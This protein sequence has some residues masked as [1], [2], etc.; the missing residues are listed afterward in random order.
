MYINSAMGV[1]RE[2]ATIITIIIHQR[3]HSLPLERRARSGPHKFENTL[4]LFIS[5]SFCVN[6]SLCLFFLCRNYMNDSLRTDVFVRYTPETVACACISLSARQIGLPLPSNPPWYGLMGASDHE[7]EDI[8]LTILKLYTRKIKSYEW[9]DKK[10]ERC[11][12]VIQEAKLRAKGQLTESGANSQAG[13]PSSFSPHTSRPTSPKVNNDSPGIPKM[14]KVNSNAVKEEV[15]SGSAGSTK[16]RENGKVDKHKRTPST[17]IS[18]RSRSSSRGRRSESH[19]P[20]NR[21]SSRD[22][23]SRSRS[24]SPRN[25]RKRQS[26]SKRKRD[27]HKRSRRDRSVSPKHRHSR[28]TKRN[29]TPPRGYGSRSLSRSRSRSRERRQK[30]HYSPYNDSAK[31]SSHSRH[32]S[33]SKHSRRERT[34]SR[35]RS[36]I[37]RSRKSKDSSRSHSND[38]R[39]R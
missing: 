31:E 26:S 32:K 29:R 14:Y 8:C 39:R 30:H 33:R 10:V 35:S 4:L 13:T 1:K 38:H 11:R 3:F 23:S 27:D 9:L 5:E 2:E 24:T 37:S 16:S 12:M 7:V 22:R 20:A 18:S 15:H 6:H 17:S 28:K 25:H 19:S 36:P 34:R 21:H